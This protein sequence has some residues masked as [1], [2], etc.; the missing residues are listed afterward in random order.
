M[1]SGLIRT[2]TALAFVLAALAL[3]TTRAEPPALTGTATS[4]EEGAMEGV[5]VSA[6][7]P[8][9]TVTVTV[10]TDPQ[11][12]YRFPAGKLAPGGYIFASGRSATS[13]MG[14]PAP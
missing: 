14:S 6:H 11:G 9:S 13:W 8:S 10:V 12:R 4:A 2:A 1:R 7:R 5:L 3:T